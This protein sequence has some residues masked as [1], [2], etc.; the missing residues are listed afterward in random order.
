MKAGRIKNKISFGAVLV[1]VAVLLPSF[2]T[3]KFTDSSFAG[4]LV[5]G[6]NVFYRSGNHFDIPEFLQKTDSVIIPLKRAGRLFLIEAKVDG[7]TGN[8]VFDTG[9]NGLVLNST[10]FRNHV[11]S[12]G[13]TSNGITGAVGTVEQVSVGQLEFADLR[14]SKLTADLANLGHIENRRGAK[15]IGLIG[16]SLLRSLEIVIDPKHNELRLYK[17]DKSGNRFNS[18]GV[19]FRSD[20]AQ[21]IE[22]TGNILFLTGTVGGKAMNFCFDT[23][24]ETNAISSDSNKKVM[25]TITITRRAAL[26][27]AGAAGSEVLFGRMNDFTIGTRRIADMETVITNLDALSE[28]YGTHIDGMLGS[29]FIEHGVFCV[30]FLSGKLGMRFTKGGEK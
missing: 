9:A 1:A 12:G 23:G 26:K 14:F 16:F 8:L 19:G 17:I 25:S 7:E 13:V 5:P 22:G 29:S 3:I 11:K 20:F 4:T 30:N 21:R 18:N 2:I 24:A 28:A 6:L 10:Y 27:G 15:I